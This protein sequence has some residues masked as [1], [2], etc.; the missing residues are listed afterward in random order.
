[1]TAENL[2][3]RDQML[4]RKAF[5]YALY[6]NN[7]LSNKATLNNASDKDLKLL[8]NVCSSIVRGDIPF[9]SEDSVNELHRR[10]RL[11]L[12]KKTLGTKSGLSTFQ[13]ESRERKLKFFYSFLNSYEIILFSLFNE[14]A[15]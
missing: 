10:K 12:L 7:T 11:M 15:K 9:K 6:E 13:K 3:L 8:A 14:E 2:R 1:M 5:L 4:F